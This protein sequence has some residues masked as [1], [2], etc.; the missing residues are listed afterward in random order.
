MNL[1]VDKRDELVWK[2]NNQELTF[3]STTVWESIRS[4]E[5]NVEWVKGV[6][7]AQCIPRHAFNLWLI[8]RGKLLTQDR[9][10]QWP[11]ARRKNMNMMCCSLCTADFD[12]HSHLF[13]ECPYSSQVWCNIRRLASMQD[14]STSWED[15]SDW[16]VSKA[17]SKSVSNII[18]RLLVAATAYYIWQERNTRMFANHARP[19]DV[20][21]NIIKETVRAKLWRLKFKRTARVL[22]VLGAWQVHGEAI[23]QDED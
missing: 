18:G 9:I 10:L 5:Q 1:Q 21:C 23:L 13:F 4:R 2:A 19:P 11:P 20:L 8:M 7:F 15:V 3:S 6:W 22:S 16:L 12:S 14:V 17:N